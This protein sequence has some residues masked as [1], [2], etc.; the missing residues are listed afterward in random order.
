MAVYGD[1]T[2]YPGMIYTWLSTLRLLNDS[3][4]DPNQT[5]KYHVVLARMMASAFIFVINHR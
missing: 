1:A 5:K 4:S 2:S 3:G